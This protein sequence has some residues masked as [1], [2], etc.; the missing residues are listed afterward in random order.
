MHALEIGQMGVADHQTEG[1]TDC[2][3]SFDTL[4]S[5]VVDCCGSEYVQTTARS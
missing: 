4:I 3:M 5:E 1:R 2:R